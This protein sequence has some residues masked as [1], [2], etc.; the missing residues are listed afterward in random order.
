LLGK[1]KVKE[2]YAGPSVES[3]Q[4]SSDP[5]SGVINV[6]SVELLSWK[7]L[8]MLQNIQIVGGWE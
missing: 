4:T 5:E 2:R 1:E 6:G 8:R 3:G 7:N